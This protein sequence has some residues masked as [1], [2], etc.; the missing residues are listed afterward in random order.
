M[1]ACADWGKPADAFRQFIR[2]V[3]T[4]QKPFNRGLAPLRSRGLDSEDAAS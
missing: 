1:D 4:A 3:V 2:R